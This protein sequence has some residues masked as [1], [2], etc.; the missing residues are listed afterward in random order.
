MQTICRVDVYTLKISKV[1]LNGSLFYV[2][3]NST[4]KKEW[5]SKHCVPKGH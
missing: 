4:S 3:K 2:N 5:S 1:D